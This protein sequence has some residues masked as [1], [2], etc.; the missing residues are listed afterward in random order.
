MEIARLTHAGDWSTNEIVDVP[1]RKDLENA[2]IDT[3]KLQT[4]SYYKINALHQYQSPEA[5]AV[6][7]KREVM[8]HFGGSI[9][10]VVVNTLLIDLKDKQPETRKLRKAIHDNLAQVKD[11]VD[12]DKRQGYLRTELEAHLRTREADE[13]PG[14]IIPLSTLYYVTRASERS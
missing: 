9:I 12:I 11:Q 7:R 6:K 4:D 8:S 5:V 1:V 10:T 3:Q 14:A 13:I 2:D